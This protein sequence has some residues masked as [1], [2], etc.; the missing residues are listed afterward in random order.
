[1]AERVAKAKAQVVQQPV[2]PPQDTKA[3]A[4]LDSLAVPTSFSPSQ[5]SKSK[6][7]GID[8]DWLFDSSARTTQ[9]EPSI[10]KPSA[11]DW[12]LEDFISRP[13]PSDEAPP[14][15]SPH[16]NSLLDLDDFKSSSERNEGPASSTRNIQPSRSDTPGDFDFGDRENALLGDDSG[17][18]D[19][20]L[21]DL[22][23]PVPERSAERPF[24]PVCG[25]S[26]TGQACTDLLTIL[27]PGCP[28]RKQISL[29]PTPSRWSD[30]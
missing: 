5:P 1:M 25:V 19:D 23:R 3:W 14:A 9:V 2:A 7:S 22:V 24:P 28:T 18:D 12:G 21:G 27:F 26:L 20:I 4:G 10:P 13:K 29:S 16:G 8:N 6:L 15:P 30:C 17:S 11:D